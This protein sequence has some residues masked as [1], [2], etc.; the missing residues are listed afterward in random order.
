MN[1]I[2][3]LE[4]AFARHDQL[5][6]PPDG[7]VEQAYVGARRIRRRRLTVGGLGTAAVLAI[8]AVTPVALS[9]L[10][11]D[12][13]RAAAPASPTPSATP[14][15][16]TSTEPAL[17]VDVDRTSGFYPLSQGFAGTVALATVRSDNTSVTGWGGNVGLYPAN[18]VDAAALSAGEPITVAGHA[19]YYVPDYLLDP[20]ADHLVPQ[21]AS[22]PK[23][24][25]I[26]NAPQDRYEAVIA[27]PEPSGAWVLVSG[28]ERPDLQRLAEAVRLTPT[29]LTMP[30]RLDYVPAGL[31]L[32]YGGSATSQPHTNSVLLFADSSWPV[33]RRAQQ[34][35]LVDQSALRIQVTSRGDTFGALAE[36]APTMIAGR[37]TWYFEGPG[38]GLGA[39]AGASVLFARVGSCEVLIRAADTNRVPYPAVKQL[40][41]GMSFQDCN[42]P[43]TWVKPLP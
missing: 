16:A 23:S 1:D 20:A 6:P 7:M 5:A 14:A 21:N 19:A 24:T 27:W 3:D 40:F 4:A 29:A 2:R 32:D 43:Q 28:S 15:V 9:R 37:E 25:S 34:L 10:G 41:E 8:A 36:I 33:M 31:R 30:Y 39:S 12:S 17:K 26:D 18:R 13:T 35:G 11:D 38:G 22:S 42:A